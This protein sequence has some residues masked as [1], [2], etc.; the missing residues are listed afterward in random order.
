MSLPDYTDPI[1]KGVPPSPG[2]AQDNEESLSGHSLR[3]SNGFGAI[4]TKTESL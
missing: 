4:A 2:W 1:I 3:L